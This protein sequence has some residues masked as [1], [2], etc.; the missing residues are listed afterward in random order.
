[1]AAAKLGADQRM[2]GGHGLAQQVVLDR[3][4]RGADLALDVGAGGAEDEVDR[5]LREPEFGEVVVERGARA[6]L[7]DAAQRVHLHVF[8]GLGM[9]AAHQRELAV[10][11]LDQRIGRVRDAQ[12]GHAL[13]VGGQDHVV[14][15][16][17][18][19][20]EAA[21]RAGLA[22][23]DGGGRAQ[24]HRGQ[25]AQ[26]PLA[27][28]DDDGAL[29]DA[30]EAEEADLAEAGVEVGQ[31]VDGLRHLGE[32]IAARVERVAGDGHG[33]LRGKR[34]REGWLCA[35]GAFSGGAGRIR[36]CRAG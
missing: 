33:E 31:D 35:A 11:H 1:M 19:Q 30:L 20:G 13:D 34:G 18:R 27:L 32:R 4:Q 7:H 6:I 3:A 14:M 9:L 12:R 5:D 16:D 17:P 15:R 22:V 29:G 25:E 26:H 24:R 36:R 28:L 23:A 10:H 2:G 8:A 21:H